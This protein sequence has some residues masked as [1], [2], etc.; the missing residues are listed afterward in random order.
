MGIEI[1]AINRT[2]EGRKVLKPTSELGSSNTIELRAKMALGPDGSDPNL[3][4]KHLFFVYTNDKNNK[5]YISGYPDHNPGPESIDH[6]DRPFGNIIRKGGEYEDGTPDFKPYVHVATITGDPQSVYAFY[7]D[8]KTKVANIND[9]KIPYGPFQNSNSTAVTAL[10]DTL[11]SRGIKFDIPRDV[12]GLATP[13]SMNNLDKPASQV[14]REAIS[15][16]KELAKE[17][18][19]PEAVQNARNTL[20]DFKQLSQDIQNLPQAIQQGF[21]KQWEKLEKQL[22]E[23]DKLCESISTQS[24]TNELQPGQSLVAE[25]IRAFFAANRSPELAD[26]YASQRLQDSATRAIGTNSNNLETNSTIGREQRSTSS[27][28]TP[29][30]RE[31]LAQLETLIGTMEKEQRVATREAQPDRQTTQQANLPNQRDDQHTL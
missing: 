8:L 29:S 3:L 19:S 31:T 7:Q 6:L 17:N 2:D 4:P 23:Y 30:L 26:R 12:N 18:V 22:E 5:Y 10:K 1:K 25:R 27:Y 21:Y 16:I 20:Q 9:A 14:Y 28:E 11:A 13:G 15:S 24:I